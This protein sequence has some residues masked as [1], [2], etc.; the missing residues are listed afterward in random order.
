MSAGEAIRKFNVEL[1][2]HL[3]LENHLFFAMVKQADL[4]PLDTGNAIA[5]KPTRSEKVA[6][7]L[8]TI[9]SGAEEYL[10]K[11]LTVMKKSEVA[12]VVNLADEIQ[13]ATGIGTYITTYMCAQ[14][15]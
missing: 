6:Y 7:F 10:P 13:A 5:A 15:I 1:H 14:L 2:R 4:F 12:D 9:E 3:P 11:L 8:T